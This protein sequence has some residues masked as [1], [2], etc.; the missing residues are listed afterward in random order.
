MH[1]IIISLFLL[2]GLP[3]SAK[4]GK[5]IEHGPIHEAF[6]EK[7]SGDI[8]LEALPTQPPRNIIERVPKQP[9]EK[10]IWIPGYWA[11]D[12]KGTDFIWVCGVWRLP[13]PTHDWQPGFWKKFDEGWVFLKGFWNQNAVGNMT[14]IS[15]APPEN[16]NE[17]TGEA[18]ANNTFWISG[19]WNWNGNEYQWLTGKWEK[20]DRDFVFV[21]A[22]YE[23]REEGY[24][25]IPAYWDHSLE[26][27]GVAFS[28]LDIPPY[29]RSGYV[30]T[31]RNIIDYEV[32]CQRL[33][34]Y[35]PDY[36]YFFQHH[37]Y[38]HQEFWLGFSWTPP[39]WVWN[40]WWTLPQG[41]SWGLWWWWCH[42]NYPAPFWMTIDLSF[43]FFGPLMDLI[44]HMKNIPVP[45]A[46]LTEAKKEVLKN[47]SPLLPK[48]KLDEIRENHKKPENTLKPQG[49]TTLE[50]LERR[51]QIKP[52]ESLDPTPPSSKPQITPPYPN[53][54][55]PERPEI[56]EVPTPEKPSYRP[57]PQYRPQ[58]QPQYRPQPHRPPPQQHYPR[59]KR[60]RYPEYQPRPERPRPK[61]QVSP[62]PPQNVP[63]YGPTE[64]PRTTNPK[65][66]GSEFF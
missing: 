22:H 63:N 21:P 28:C 38:W 62:N 52:P 24:I 64:I 3:L 59:P 17:K 12:E 56:R 53:P 16:L 26:E 45:V 58:P 55:V 36:C 34:I 32:I 20:I 54:L 51:P 11:F 18:P 8:I 61:P 2:A 35:Y 50:E 48:E 40:S 66:S 49:R 30:F 13:P 19:Y 42:P 60:P 7:L 33:F 31:P 6:V 1:K 25:F 65:K 9:N 14:Y 29:A 44:D 46:L 43:L 27:R 39:W 10:M 15:K 5:P 23:W 41:D 37:W 4:A 57:D 47:N